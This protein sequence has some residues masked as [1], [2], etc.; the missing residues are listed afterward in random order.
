MKCP[1]CGG[2]AVETGDGLTSTWK[3]CLNCGKAWDFR[4]SLQD[5]Y[6]ESIKD[7]PKI[8]RKVTEETMPF[9]EKPETGCTH[10]T[11]N[12][13]GRKFYCGDPRHPE[14]KWC[15]RHYL[16]KR[17][18]NGAVTSRAAAPM[19]KQEPPAPIV[20]VN[21]NIPGHARKVIEELE[22]KAVNLENEVKILRQTIINLEAV[23]QEA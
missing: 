5:A 15:E 2:F 14:S 3:S 4:D 16:K 19:P 12:A 6:L 7:L 20:S 22:K 9:S 8:E 21:G 11:T 23:Y 18:N 10:Y 13:T 17:K 1:K